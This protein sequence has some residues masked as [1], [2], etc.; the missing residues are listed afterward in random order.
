MSFKKKTANAENSVINSSSLLWLIHYHIYP[1]TASLTEKNA[2]ILQSIHINKEKK[3]LYSSTHLHMQCYLVQ[4]LFNSD[5]YIE[6]IWMNQWN[7]WHIDKAY[8]INSTIGSFDMGLD[9]PSTNIFSQIAPGID[10]DWEHKLFGT[11]WL[12]FLLSSNKWK[13]KK[14]TET[15]SER[16]ACPFAFASPLINHHTTPSKAILLSSVTFCIDIPL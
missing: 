7:W 2:C 14:N 3:H 11:W 15:A 9:S 13:Q 1:Y 12:K 8:S 5:W 6:V 4:F 10:L 16:L